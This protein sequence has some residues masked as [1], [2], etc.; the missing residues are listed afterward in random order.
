MSYNN[1]NIYLYNTRPTHHARN[2]NVQ[3][4]HFSENKSPGAAPGH[5]SD[6]F[7]AKIRTKK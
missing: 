5:I 1:R 6:E 2:G 7:T 3:L 4:P